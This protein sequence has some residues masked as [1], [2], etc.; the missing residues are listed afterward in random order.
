MS[1]S[2][3]RYINYKLINS[4]A[5]P[6][7]SLL[8][9]EI[10]QLYYKCGQDDVPDEQ[11]DQDSLMLGQTVPQTPLTGVLYYRIDWNNCATQGRKPAL[12]YPGINRSL[13]FTVVR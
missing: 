6:E 7:C 5:L 13:C 11:V 2:L 10:I 3:K 1:V 8:I 9:L 4:L 12:N